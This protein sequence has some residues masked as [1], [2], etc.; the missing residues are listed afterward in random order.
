MKSIQCRGYG[1]VPPSFFRKA[2]SVLAADHPTHSEDAAEKLVENAVHAGV[3]GLRPGGGHE[4][5]VDIAVSGVAE[6]GDRDAIF[7]LQPGG[8]VEEIE[9]PSSW[10]GDVLV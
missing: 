7:F 6:A 8:E 3:V 5:D 9:D 10:D 1:P 4:V 2:D